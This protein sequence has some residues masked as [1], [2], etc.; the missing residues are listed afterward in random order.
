MDIYAKFGIDKDFG[1]NQS[2]PGLFISDQIKSGAL[3]LIVTSAVVIGVAWLVNSSESWWFWTF[4]FLFGVLLVINMLGQEIHSLMEKTGF[5]AAGVFKVDASKRD[6]RLNAYFGGMGKT[7]RVVLFDTLIEKLNKQ[8]LLAVLGHEL[9]HFKHGDIWKNLAVI[10]GILFVFLG[11]FGNLPSELYTEIGVTDEP[12]SLMV[13]FMLLS[14]PLFF[15]LMP[16]FNGISRRNEFAAD[17]F[18]AE[19]VDGRALAMALVKLSEANKRFPHSATLYKFFYETHPGV[20]ER[21]EK[22][23]AEELL[24]PLRELA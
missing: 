21:V 24:T 3:T 1:F 18:G 19:L 12:S 16:F 4:L 22:L 15:I 9:G 6:A 20:P 23:G 2:T 8:E 11:L 7:K 13:L 14:T 5:Q 17:R 10:G